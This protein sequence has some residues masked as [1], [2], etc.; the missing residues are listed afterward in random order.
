MRGDDIEVAVAFMTQHRASA[1]TE[2]K[3]ETSE[4][5]DFAHM[6]SCQILMTG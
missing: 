2:W 1:G 5:N 3:H 6:T 4:H